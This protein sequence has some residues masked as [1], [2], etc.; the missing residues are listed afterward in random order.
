MRPQL[1]PLGMGCGGAWVAG[2]HSQEVM[3]L[4]AFQELIYK[5]FFSQGDLVGRE[6]PQGVQAGGRLPVW[7]WEGQAPSLGWEALG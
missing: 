1:A 4:L 3:R 5:E 6:W 7:G 2:C